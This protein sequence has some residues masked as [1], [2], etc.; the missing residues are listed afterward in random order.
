MTKAIFSRILVLVGVLSILVAPVYGQSGT[1]TGTVLDADTGE[2]LSNVNVGLVETPIGAATG[3]SGQFAISNVPVGEYTVKASLVGHL[4]VERE[5]RVRTGETTELEIELSEKAVELGGITVTG[6]RGGYVAAEAMTAS[7]IDVARTETPQSVTVINRS[8]LTVRG[9]DRLS[10]ALRYTPGVQGET[11]GF[12]PRTA[13][14][15]FRGFDATTSGLYRNGLQLRNPSF[16]VGYSPEPYGAQRIE[17]PKGPSSVLYGAGSPGGLVNFVSKR[18]TQE[19]YGEVAIEP[20][21]ESRWQGK[22]DLSGPIDQDGTFSYRLTSL[23]RDSETQVDHIQNDRV[24]VAPAL[25]WRPTSSTKL[26]VLGRY[27][28]DNTRSSQRLP[29][30]GTLESNPNGEIPVNRFLGEPGADQY[31]RSQWSV[32][33]LFTQEIGSAWTFDQKLRYY[34]IDLDDVTVFGSALRDDQRT[35]D[36]FLFESF[37]ELGGFALDN[38]GQVRVSTG[39]VDQTLLFGVDVQ[40]IQVGSEQNFGAAPPIDIIDPNYGKDVPEPSPFKDVD[41]TQR[42]VGVYL[43]D[44]VDLSDRWIATLNGRYD[45]ADTKTENNLEDSD[46]E[47]TDSEFSWRAGLVYESEIGLAPYAS[48]SQ[49]FL[50]VVGTDPDGEPFSPERGEQWEL[51]V[52]YQPVGSNSFLSV[53]LFDLTRENFLQTDPETFQQVQTGDANSQGIEVRGVASYANGLDLTASITGQD[54]EIVESVVG[55]EEGERPTQVREKMGTLWADYT[56]QEGALDGVGVGA[57]VRYL[58]PSYGDVPNT[59][60]APAVTLVDA[61]VHYDWN[62]F[63][64]QVN[65]DNVLDNEHVASTFVSGGQEFATYGAARRVTASIRYRW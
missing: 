44:H 14:L 51:G 13:F 29:A 8:Q 7:K 48:Y 32:G 21:T 2:P 11:F 23:V 24:F 55:E 30:S 53:A 61:T 57:G 3:E 6:R 19:P 16:A 62:G 56:V 15:R 20:G 26:T 65:A 5:I 28:N 46:T 39:P 25:S 42:Q 59:L 41:I 18:P 31:D 47:Q 9:V 58:G 10:E 38:Q 37:G 60:K 54:V 17:V 52:K 4:A 45:W 33:Y 34:S 12:E 35:L 36:R 63:R 40:R 27:Q 22:I 64:V 1:I 50:P 43:Q 49:S